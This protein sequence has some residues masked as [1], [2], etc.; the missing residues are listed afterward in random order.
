MCQYYNQNYSE[1]DVAAILQR[2]QDCVRDGNYS[3][4]LNEFRKEN[5]DFI[6]KII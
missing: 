1:E 6:E 4:S 5:L 3:I 2:I